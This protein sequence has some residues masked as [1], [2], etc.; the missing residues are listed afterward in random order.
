MLVGQRC[1]LVCCQVLTPAQEVFLDVH[2]YPWWPDLWYMSGKLAEQA[3]A[4][5][6][7]EQNGGNANA[8]SS[9]HIGSA[10]ASSLFLLPRFSAFEMLQEPLLARGCGLQFKRSVPSL[11]LAAL[12]KICNC[13]CIY[14]KSLQHGSSVNQLFR[15][16]TFRNALAQSTKPAL[17]QA[18][19]IIRAW[20]SSLSSA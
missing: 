16:N 7:A 11:C 18:L 10:T 1:I 6:A 12:L 13:L 5:A 2:S 19:S 14:T 9:P 17:R 3:L 15:G 20:Q 4:A 8:S